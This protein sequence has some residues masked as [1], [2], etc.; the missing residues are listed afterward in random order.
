MWRKFHLYWGLLTGLSLFPLLPRLIEESTLL[1]YQTLLGASLWIVSAGFIC[2]RHKFKWTLPQTLWLLFLAISFSITAIHGRVTPWMSAQWAAAALYFCMSVWIFGKTDKKQLSQFLL[3]AIAMLCVE[4]A[5][6]YTQYIKVLCQGE[7]ITAVTGT[8]DN[9]TG[10]ATAMVLLAVLTGCFPVNEAL[11]QKFRQHIKRLVTLLATLL[12]ILLQSRS[13]ILALLVVWLVGNQSLRKC[14]I[15]RK[16]TLCVGCGLLLVVLA[17]SL[18]FLKKDSAD[19]RLLIYRC[20]TE[21]ISRSPWTGYG[22]GGFQAGYMDIQVR[23][24]ATHPNSSFALLADDVR[25]PMSEML[26]LLTE[27]G[28][29]GL[30]PLLLLACLALFRMRRSTDAESR[31]FLFVL[32]GMGVMSVFSYPLTYTF[33]QGAVLTAAA[34]ALRAESEGKTGSVRNK[35]TMAVS[36]AAGIC[37]FIIAF[38]YY[39]LERKWFYACRTAQTELPARAITAYEKLYPELHDKGDF[40]YNYAITSYEASLPKRSDSLLAEYRHW[41]W[42]TDC[43]LTGADNALF[44]GD[45]VRAKELLWQAHHMKPVRF[46]PL[47]KLLK[48]AQ[49]QGLDAEARQLAGT[50]LQKR[51]KIPSAE[52]DWMKEDARNILHSKARQ[53]EKRPINRR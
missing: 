29:L 41:D 42:S 22:Q 43:A 44:E 39:R 21:L 52:T 10:L 2:S 6:G 40:L 8:F 19:G 53:A 13:G 11:Q 7:P 27:Y 47:Y 16:A 50:I 31:T 9:S 33:V 4:M 20:T 15:R 46:L 18:Y 1:F 38:R 45:T 26:R 17:I 30:L 37:V 35:V 3:S 23:Y 36:L 34:Y 28:I 51:I 49:A 5:I 25:Q 48:L 24:F 32:L 12:V 14:L